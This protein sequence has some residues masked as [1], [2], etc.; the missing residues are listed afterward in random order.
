MPQILNTII[1]A[2]RQKILEVAILR[3]ATFAENYYGKAVAPAMGEEALKLAVAAAQGKLS[4]GDLIVAEVSLGE[5]VTPYDI[6][7][8]VKFSVGVTVVPVTYPEEFGKAEHVGM[9]MLCVNS[10]GSFRSADGEKRTLR[11]YKYIMRPATEEEI[12]AVVD[13][14]L[15]TRPTTTVKLFSDKMDE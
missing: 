7:S 8:T 9:P 15:A 14:L 2:K 12:T 11:A 4:E 6:R 3:T 13:G 5:K 1:N 10:D